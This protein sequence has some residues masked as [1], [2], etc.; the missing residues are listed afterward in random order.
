MC[1]DYKRADINRR[2]VYLKQN[3]SGYLE[4]EAFLKA[5]PRQNPLPS[6]IPQGNLIIVSKREISDTMHIVEGEY[7]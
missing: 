6:W 7:I 1:L 3:I 5:H 4:V 2:M